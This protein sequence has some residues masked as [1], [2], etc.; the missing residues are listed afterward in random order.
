MR[1]T[2]TIDGGGRLNACSQR[3]ALWRWVGIAASTTVATLLTTSGLQFMSSGVG[4]DVAGAVTS[5][6]AMPALA[7][8][9]MVTTP[10]P[11]AQPPRLFAVAAVTI[12]D[13][14]TGCNGNTATLDLGGNNTGNPKGSTT[15][16]RVATS[17]KDPCT[18]QTLAASKQVHVATGSITF[19]LCPNPG[20]TASYISLHDLTHIALSIA[21]QTV[22]IRNPTSSTASASANGAGTG[23]ST[24]RPATASST[25]TA[26]SLAFT[27]A[28]IAAMTV[29]GS[30]V[31]VLGA[32]VILLARRRRSQSTASSP[33]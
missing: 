29:G 22:V 7:H 15:I 32:F 23:A 26:G 16:F 31:I 18:G 10:S 12:S 25:A 33:S 19:G 28:E 4:Q 8:F 9:K 20:H 6:G 24:A 17:A 1:R 2:L 14:A 3:S 5:C 21:G 27:G 11:H 13:L 30:L